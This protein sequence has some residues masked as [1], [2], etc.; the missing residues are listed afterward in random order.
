MMRRAEITQCDVRLTL[1]PLAKR[2]RDVRLADT[3]LPRQEHHPTFPLRGVSPPAQQ[4]L[5]L[6]FTPE[7]RGQLGL[8][9]R[10]EA[11]L[12]AACPQHLPN[13]YRLRPAFQRERAEIAVIEVPSR[14]P[15]RLRA[16]QH[17]P[18]LRNRLQARGE[19]RRLADNR[20]FRRGFINQKLAHNDRAGRNANASLKRGVDIC[21]EIRYGVDE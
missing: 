2:E 11:A 1:E 14:E 3:W 21:L 20:L 19:V 10:L 13:R 4:Q 16:D 18:W 15:T 8:V 9:H 7:Q 12:H 6:L 17:C 5:D